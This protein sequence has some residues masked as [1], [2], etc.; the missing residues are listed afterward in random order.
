MDPKDTLED[1]IEDLEKVK[2]IEITFRKLDA[3]QIKTPRPET[4]ATSAR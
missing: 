3:S 4:L 2:G 1:A